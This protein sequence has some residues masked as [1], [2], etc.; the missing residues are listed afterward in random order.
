MTFTAKRVILSRYDVCNLQCESFANTFCEVAVVDH[1]AQQAREHERQLFVENAV[2]VADRYLM[3]K[4]DGTKEM[5]D[6]LTAELA[7]SLLYMA[8]KPLH[9]SG[10]CTSTDT[11]V[12]T[13]VAMVMRLL[14][15]E[16]PEDSDDV[17]NYLLWRVALRFIDKVSC[18]FISAFVK[19]E[20]ENPAKAE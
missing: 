19:W 15:E 17:R 11:T 1:D 6:R 20:S 14:R 10:I 5:T 7:H 9:V 4:S 13:S 18:V 8:A 2:N 16:C 3:G 12:C